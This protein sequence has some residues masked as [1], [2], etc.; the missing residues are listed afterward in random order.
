MTPPPPRRRTSTAIRLPDDIHD[1]LVAAA[2]ERMVSA[3][4]LVIKALEDFLPRL[5]P[6]DELRLTRTET[7]SRPTTAPPRHP[8]SEGW[9]HPDAASDEVTG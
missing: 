2:H 4:W 7:L 3:N 6:A 9:T 8:I 5:I 1:L